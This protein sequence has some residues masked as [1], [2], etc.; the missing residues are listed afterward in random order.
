MENFKRKGIGLFGMMG[1]KWSAY[2]TGGL[3]DYTGP[4]WV[5]GTPSRPEAFLN[6]QDTA[7]IA[8]LVET[9][10]YLSYPLKSPNYQS[11]SNTSNSQNTYQIEI[12]IG[13]LGEN[14][15]VDD[16]MEEIGNKIYT[17]S[18]TNKITRV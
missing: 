14:Y 8:A 17:I 5:D 7:N 1:N 11:Q 16:L 15:T 18:N 13:E 6:A 10:Q 12:N 9:L 4:A 2:A 3:V